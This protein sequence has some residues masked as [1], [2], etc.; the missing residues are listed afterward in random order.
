MAKYRHFAESII[1]Q[2]HIEKG[3]DKQDYALSCTHR[4]AYI[5]V[6]GDGHGSAPY[7]RSKIG[8]ELVCCVARDKI[9]D[10]L[11]AVPQETFHP[12]SDAQVK[13][14]VGQLL[15]K[16][17]ESIVTCWRNAIDGHL[18]SHPFT[19][20][21]LATVP[22]KHAAN[23]RARRHIEHAY[24]TTLIAVV[25][26]ESIWFA[27]HIGDGRC[28][29]LNQRGDFVEP[30][31][32]DDR[33]QLN[34]CTSICDED[35]VNEFR[36]WISEVPPAA[37]YIASDGVDDSYG[38]E[39]TPEKAILL[40]SLYRSISLMFA[41][42]GFAKAQR[43]VHEYLPVLTQKGSKDDVSIAAIIDEEALAALAPILEID[44]E[45]KT[46]RQQM[47]TLRAKESAQR[48]RLR[49]M[50]ASFTQLEA[51]P[52]DAITRVRE[53]IGAL[54][55]GLDALRQICDEIAVLDDKIAT[56][57]AKRKNMLGELETSGEEV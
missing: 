41:R 43:Y 32:W 36:Y 31:A 29:A 21:E 44:A 50:G 47:T 16:L 52:R 28:V 2:S 35:A 46:S 9:K 49:Q 45:L 10:F 25:V 39:N 34:V 27:L 38:L 33:C 5:A 17:T 40:H 53:K 7:V 12:L 23:Y 54:G 30:I 11:D 37:V 24:G 15:H 13:K 42:D 8:S 51:I 1:G 3:T 48:D 26:C 57:C 14:N 19:E 18:S 20:E 55:E 6:V 4:G 22:E 56:L